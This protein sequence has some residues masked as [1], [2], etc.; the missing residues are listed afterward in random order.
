MI[1]ATLTSAASSLVA[2][3][4]EAGPNTAMPPSFNDGAP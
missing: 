3:S 1:L 2:Q 4:V